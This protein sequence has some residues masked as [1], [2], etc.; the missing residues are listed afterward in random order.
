MWVRSSCFGRRARAGVN[1]GIDPS[2]YSGDEKIGTTM[3]KFIVVAAAVVTA[4]LGLAGPASAGEGHD[5]P[6][7]SGKPVTVCHATASQ[8]NPYVKLPNVPL[9]QFLGQNGHEEHEGDIWAA[10]SYIVRTGPEQ[11]DYETVNVPAQGNQA[12]LAFDNCQPPAEDTPVT[13]PEPVFNDL[14]GTEN[15]VF[16]VAPGTGFTVSP[17]QLIAG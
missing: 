11:G 5:H 10:F 6:E 8:S 9:V 13:K 14:C 12:L 4:M 2:T 17:V 16:S 7:V 3:K 15:D 1:E